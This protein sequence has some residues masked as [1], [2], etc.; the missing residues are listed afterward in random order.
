MIK[1]ITEDTIARFL[2][3]DIPQLLVKIGY[4]QIVIMN[5]GER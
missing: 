1:P 3:G 4:L 2:T 5:G